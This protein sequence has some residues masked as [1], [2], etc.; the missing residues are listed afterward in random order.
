MVM[1]AWGSACWVR[2]NTVSF[3]CA[4]STPSGCW[5]MRSR[6]IL[7][8]G[9]ESTVWSPHGLL[10]LAQGSS[11]PCRGQEQ[12]VLRVL[13]IPDATRRCGRAE[14]RVGAHR[15]DLAWGWRKRREESSC[16]VPLGG[17]SPWLCGW[18]CWEAFCG[19]LGTGSL[20]E[21]LFH[22]SPWPIPMKRD[23]SWF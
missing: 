22:C 2:W 23:S 13:G 8:W 12:Q 9:W 20:E 5:A 4:Y 18:E 15:Q 3:D 16:W 6:G 11:D 7:L 10:E 14:N 21:D 17:E 1:S 19:R